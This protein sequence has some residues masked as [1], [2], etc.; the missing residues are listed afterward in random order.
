[1]KFSKWLQQWLG[2]KF[3]HTDAK[4]A[5]GGGHS[6]LRQAASAQLPIQPLEKRSLLTVSLTIG[7]D[8]ADLA[9]PRGARYRR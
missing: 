2:A 8:V 6:P 4:P 3:Y 1:M 9:G 7:V 5:R